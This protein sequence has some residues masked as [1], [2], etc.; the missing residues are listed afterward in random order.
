MA[1][2]FAV[3]IVP[4]EHADATELRRW[5][6]DGADIRND[7]DIA[8][9]V[10]AFVAAA[11]AGSVV[12]TTHHRLPARRRHRLPRANLSRVHIL[13]GTRSLDRRALTLVPSSKGLGPIPI[14]CAARSTALSPIP[15]A[16]AE[17]GWLPR[18]IAGD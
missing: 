12:T 15:A 17:S 13:G 11:G 9:E 8:E 1:T 10:L 3:G 4:A 18:L 7:A 6:S 14:G 5:F 16:S 2:K